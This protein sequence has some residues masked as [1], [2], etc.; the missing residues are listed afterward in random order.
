[1]TQADR[2]SHWGI[3]DWREPGDYGPT[4]T[5]DLDRWRWEFTR[6]RPDYRRDFIAAQE[7]VSN[8]RAAISSQGSQPGAIPHSGAGKYGLLAFFDPKLGEY[9]GGLRPRWLAGIMPFL[10]LMNP[11]ELILEAKLPHTTMMSFDFSKPIGAQLEQAKVVLNALQ[12]AA[13]RSGSVASSADT[14]L[15]PTKWLR[16]LRV[17]DARD[18]GAKWSEIVA[19]VP[20]LPAAQTIDAARDAEK[21]GR[22]GIGI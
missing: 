18:A 13:R 1:M 21:A 15:H 8:P 6:R 19:V 4:D 20:M 2:S 17:V 16:N 14:R 3:P 7:T 10:E 11:E 22:I 12:D 5:W 9:T